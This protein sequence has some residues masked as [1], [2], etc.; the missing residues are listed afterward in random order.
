MNYYMPG[1]I[2]FFSTLYPEAAD[3]NG[4]KFEDMVE[5]SDDEY[6][7]FINPPEG[8]YLVF[9]EEGPR[10]HDIPE[11]DYA[12]MAEQ[13]RSDLLREMQNV[14]YAMSSKLS[15]GRTLTEAEKN[16][17]NAW[18]DFSDSVEAL[19]FESLVSESEFN[20]IAWPKKPE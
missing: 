12:S 14:T 8:K 18:L 19:D 20:A 4:V 15:L 16:K 2:G 3:A 7:V 5:I 13:K 9:D 17:F 6:E 11:P 1:K 10:L